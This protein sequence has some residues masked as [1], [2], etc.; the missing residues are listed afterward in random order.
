MPETHA[1]TTV[2]LSLDVPLDLHIQFRIHC[3]TER[4]PMKQTMLKL[5]TEYLHKL[6][7]YRKQ[8]NMETQ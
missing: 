3:M 8:T 5:L 6:P 4:T 1:P 7:P 2:R